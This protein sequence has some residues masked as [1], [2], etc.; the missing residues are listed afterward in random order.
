MARLVVLRGET[1]DRE[2]ELIRLPVRIGRGQQ[3]DLVLEDHVKSVSRDH[4]EIRFEDGRYVLVDLE[5][6]NGIWVAGNRVPYVA[7]EPNVVASIGP[8]RLM[9]EGDAASVTSP[10]AAAS[11]ASDA[12]TQHV[13]PVGGSQTPKPRS[14]RLSGPGRKPTPESER[15]RKWAIGGAAALAAVA[16]I[17]AAVMLLRPSPTTEEP[18]QEI[19]QRVTA[20]RQ[21]IE[22]G[23]CAAAIADNIEPALARDPDNA[24]LLNLKRQAEACIASLPPSERT[25]AEAAESA[26]AAELEL[27]RDLIARGDCSTALNPH[28]NNVLSTNPDNAEAQNLKT[29]A[30][31]CS[32]LATAKPRPPPSAAVQLA[33]S[34]PPED[35]GLESLPGELD[36][37]YQLRVKAMRAR[38]DEAVSTASK[39]PSRRAITVFEGIVRDA[40]PKYLDIA[41][42]LAEARK[43]WR[44][45]AQ[46]L[47]SEAREL[48]AKGMWNEAIQKFTEAH[49]VD[50]ALSIDA[51]VRSAE[52]QKLAAGQ[53][54]CRLG[55]QT[56][57]YNR[58]VGMLH[59]RRALALLPA[60]DPCYQDAKRYVSEPA[61]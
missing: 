22:Q 7:L 21:Q 1:P 33:Q 38:Y 16:A 46:P 52:A 56:I 37:D 45:T 48:V 26:I 30:E 53:Q 28:I 25:Q 36:R 15:Q 59:F 5:S 57:S 40:T 24:D 47:M 19:A 44:A 35:G 12:G 39:G 43:A 18:Q 20:A 13:V 42:R 29:Q 50:P 17:T 11:G 41:A 51:E 61:K 8:F 3:N 34:L 58:P 32:K 2:I 60:D 54:A 14:D 4:A 23:A 6:Q 27:A 31:A 10:L 9:I 49:D 55:R